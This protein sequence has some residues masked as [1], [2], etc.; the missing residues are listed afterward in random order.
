M[1][2]QLFCISLPD[3]QPMPIP[4]Q[5]VLCLGN[6]DGVH[7]GHRTLLRSAREWR[8]ERFAKVPIGVFCFR[9]LPSD[10]L[11]DSPV[12]HLC[13]LEERLSRF[14][15]CGMEFV[16][17]AAFSELRDYSPTA[18]VEQILKE[19]C[20]CMAAACGY[21][22]HFGR[23]GKGT[24][25]LLADRFPNALLLQEQVV[26]DGDPVS[27]TRIRGLLQLG[28]P[29]KAEAQLL[30]PYTLCAPV[31]HGKALGRR[32]GSPTVNQNFPQN[33]VLPRFGVYATE[34]IAKG[35][36]Y[37]GVSNVGIHPTV[38]A[39]ACANCETYLIDFDGDL[40][41][42]TLTV[43]FRRFIR[44]E[45]KFDSVEELRARIALDVQIVRDLLA[46]N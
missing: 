17:L 19:M 41:G 35:T 45:M 24:P 43:A 5:T 34:V 20:H 26:V 29:E 23:F 27:S 10:T 44:P 18:Y 6:F 21:N 16:I 33:A 12:G 13:S 31:V 4:L 32:L 42:E 40:Y 22:H 9:D 36:R 8:D 11:S 46:E 7:L 39:G 38:D 3:Q 30:L 2:P 28:E 37:I 14:S 25:A 1:M 15:D